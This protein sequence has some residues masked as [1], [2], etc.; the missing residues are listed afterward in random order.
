M[1]N[2]FCILDILSVLFFLGHPVHVEKVV[3]NNEVQIEDDRTIIS[4]SLIKHCTV[5]NRTQSH[6]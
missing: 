4:P 1:F 3:E 5:I 2:I 6:P